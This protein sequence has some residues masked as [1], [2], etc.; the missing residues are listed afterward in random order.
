MSCEHCE[1]DLKQQMSLE[2]FSFSTALQTVSSL[3]LQTILKESVPPHLTKPSIPLTVRQ[4][5]VK[6]ASE[7][8]LDG[9]GVFNCLSG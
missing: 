8:C 4:P 3:P 5:R 6:D 2:I 7:A 1:E 9:C